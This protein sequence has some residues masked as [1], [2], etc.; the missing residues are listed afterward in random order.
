[1]SEIE[2][3][4][5]RLRWLLD[6]EGLSYRAAAERLNIRGFGGTYA[7]L[8]AV[9]NKKDP[10]V[11]PSLDL[12]WG[13]AKTFDVNPSWLAFGVGSSNDR[14]QV[15]E[16]DAGKVE[17]AAPDLPAAV[18]GELENLALAIRAR[19]AGTRGQ[20]LDETFATLEDTIRWL[21]ALVRLPFRTRL[22]R[23]PEDD[24]A[25]YGYAKPLIEALQTLLRDEIDLS[26]GDSTL[27]AVLKLAGPQKTPAPAS[28]QS[29]V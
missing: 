10:P 6:R 2:G 28:G 29:E 15:E 11:T 24:L 9:V 13:I 8:W 16:I 4:G 21:A 18:R 19:Q 23:K 17:S 7:T 1:M 26:G 22:F 27:E 25:W 20:G 5:A 14:W 12:I 3:V